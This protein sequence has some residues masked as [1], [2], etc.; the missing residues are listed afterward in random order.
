LM[1]DAPKDAK[2]LAYTS[3]CRPILDYADVVWD[4]AVR[5][6]VHDIELIQ[7]SA[8]QFI[9]DMKGHADSVS[10]A[11]DELGLQSLVDRRKNHRLCLLTRIRSYGIKIELKSK[12]K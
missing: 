7:N 10:E 3:L 4:P 8:V 11:R 6:K 5:S 12:S 2:L 1:Y 9:S